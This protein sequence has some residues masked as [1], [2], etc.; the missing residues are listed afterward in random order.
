MQVYVRPVTGRR[1][2]LRKDF[3]IEPVKVI[4]APPAPIQPAFDVSHKRR[5]EV[6]PSGASAHW[7]ASS[8]T[9]RQL[10]I[11]PCTTAASAQVYGDINFDCQ[12]TFVQV[13]FPLDT[14]EAA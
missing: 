4:P 1:H 8:A 12:F 7:Q 2:L 5:R 9:G 14:S 6:L 13:C 10:L 3:G 11:T